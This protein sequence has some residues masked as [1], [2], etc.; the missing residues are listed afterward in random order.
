MDQLP[1]SRK[2]V[3]F[4]DLLRGWAVIVMIETH[5]FNA[6]LTPDHTSSG[7]FQVLTFINGLVAPSFLFAS[8]LAYAV[9][10]RRKIHDYLS[11]GPP[12][13]KQLGR[14]LL[15]LLIGYTLHIP[16]FSYAHLR[17]IAGDRG[18]ELF[19]QVDVLHCIAVSLLLLQILLLV[20]RT[21]ARLYRV[22]PWMG[23]AVVIASPLMWGI[24]FWG[25][26]PVPVAAYMNGLHN[27]LFPLFPWS[28]FVFAGAITGRQYLLAKDRET[29]G[30]AGAIARK[31]KSVAWFG[32]GFIAFSFVL[33]PAAATVYPVYDYWRVSPSFFLLRL[34]L[35]LLLCV[36]MYS[37]ERLRGVSPRS[38]V[39]LVGRESLIVYV[40]HLTVI[41]GK[42]GSFTFSETFGR[43]FGYIE[44]ALV[45]ITLLLLMV[46]LAHAWSRVKQGPLRVRRGLQAAFLIILLGLFF[47]APAI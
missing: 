34:G 43:S 15:I 33:H 17:Y 45:T 41:Y 22:V 35:V 23:A 42:F 28:A 47:S 7:F 4:I 10:T 14:L 3:E 26:I 6:T 11:F 31:M 32:V 20:L 25:L 40:T 38:V 39:T 36:G 5:V 9:T 16:R 37:F 13:F 24:D 30:E 21:E 8:G 2:R 29:A 1:Q 46:L 18:W 44:A 27:S 12:L 19:F